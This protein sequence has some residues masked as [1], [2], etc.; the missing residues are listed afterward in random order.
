MKCPKCN[1]EMRIWNSKY[2]YKDGQLNKKLNFSCFNK[3]CTNFHKIV[4]SEYIPLEV[5]PDE[6]EGTL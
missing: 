1:T 6:E 5:S 3:D 2:V 4:S